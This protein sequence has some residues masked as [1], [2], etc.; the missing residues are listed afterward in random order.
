MT[1]AE[2]PG[3]FS[4]HMGTFIESARQSVISHG[5]IFDKFTGDGFVAYF[6]EA[7]CYRCRLDY[8]EAFFRF[9]KDQ[10]KVAP[11]FFAQWSATLRKLPDIKI[12]LAIGADYGQVEFREEQGQLIAI[13]S[14]IVWASRMAS[15]GRA[16][17]LVI[18]NQLYHLVRGTLPGKPLRRK[19]K[20]NS[21]EKFIARAYPLSRFAAAPAT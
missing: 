16:N 11:P 2:N 4:D 1:Y 3:V 20:A 13:G 6:N 5:G 8:R 7:F 15:A 9:V 18:N 19:A 10:A 17:E 14:P 21:G 12:G